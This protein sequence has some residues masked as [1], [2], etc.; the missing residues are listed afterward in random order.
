MRYKGKIHNWQ[1]DKGFGFITPNGGG[2]QVFVHINSFT[3]RLRRPVTNEVVTYSVKKDASGRTQAETV[4]FAGER[5]ALTSSAEFS[6]IPVIIVIIFVCTLTAMVAMNRAPIILLWLYGFTSLL[7]FVAYAIDKSAA[8][9][10]R[11]RIPENT[12]HLMALAGGWPGAFAAQRILRHKSSK[13]SFLIMFWITATLN[14]IALGWLF[15][16]SGSETLGA[17]YSLRR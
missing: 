10:G 4:L 17:L 13:Q 9:N 7:A 5:L 2:K 16:A 14:C 3:N 15:S 6:K 1:D 11:W 12:L 8:R